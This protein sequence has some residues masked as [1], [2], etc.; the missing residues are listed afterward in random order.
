M[1]RTSELEAGVSTSSRTRE[2]RV[3][4]L[5]PT[6]ALPPLSYRIPDSLLDKVK[7]GA[8]VIVP[9]SGYSRFGIVVGV[10]DADRSSEPVSEV[11]EELCLS[12]SLAEVCQKISEAAAMPLSSVLGA[13]LPPGL[14]TNRYRVVDPA[15]NWP[16]AA[17]SRVSRAALRRRLGG[18]GL[19]VAEDEG[20][21][22]LDIG[23]PERRHVEWAVLRRGA[24][25]DLTRAPRQRE[26]FAQLSDA[27][28]ES[29]VTGLLAATGASRAIVRA[30]VNRGAV[31]IERRP[32]PPPVL[33]TRGSMVA[34]GRGGYARGHRRDAGRVVDRG[35]AWLW[36]VPSSEQPTAVA[37]I[38]EAAA[39]G[40]EQAL[41]LVPEIKVAEQFARYICGSLPPGYTVATYHSGHGS[42][43]PVIYQMAREGRIDIVVGTRAAALLPMRRLGVICVVDEPNEAHRA[44]PGYEGLRIHVRDVALARE[45]ADGTSVAF[46]SAVPSLRIYARKDRI[47]ELAARSRRDWPA[48]RIVDL[49]GSGTVLSE[50]LIDACRRGL[51]MGGR[52]AL[53][54]NR[55][56]YA[57]SLSCNRCG[58]VQTCPDCELPLVLQEAGDC[59]TCGS[60][61][62]RSRAAGRCAVCG[63]GRI[64]PTGLGVERLRDEVA[65]ALEVPVGLITAGRREAEDA[66]VVVG[67]PRC[68]AEGNW[69]TVAVTDADNLLLEGGSISS[70]ERAFRML[71]AASE[72]ANE[73]VVVQ[74]RAPEHHALQTAL[75]GDY[76]A[77]AATE[78]P[79]LR[80]LGYPPFGHL[81]SLTLQGNEEAVQGAVESLLRPSLEPGVSMSDPVPVARPGGESVWRVLLRSVDRP[82]AARSAM[83]VARTAARQRA[84]D[85]LEVQVEIDPEE[86]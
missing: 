10:E 84:K 14:E 85:K 8:A 83:A 52:V 42:A 31:S 69:H 27:G 70:V 68:V 21:V 44:Q 32:E 17:G 76:P 33:P 75:R 35:G 49:R 39:E 2:A 22:W 6:H 28:G 78:L 48:A 61:G 24:K 79:K 77:F 82:A 43:R 20:R 25:P 60:C 5:I 55:L 3:S 74:T 13:A 58:A 86:V 23:L 46:V 72:A 47:R 38:V 9:L 29:P 65:R 19:R 80:A 40:D 56:G 57:T 41:V 53:I 81:A 37:S 30:L 16:W 1:P 66:P 34:E 71:Y 45:E 15:P 4:L 73:L 51:D 67:T 12:P 54:S 63:S 11:V 7:P 62:Y 18:E 50:E 59:A 64:S 26:L 36:R